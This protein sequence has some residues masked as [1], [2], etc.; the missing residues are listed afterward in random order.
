MERKR[1]RLRRISSEGEEDED[2]RISSRSRKRV[3][4]MEDEE[5]DESNE[6]DDEEEDD[7]QPGLSMQTGH[8]QRT[9]GN[10]LLPV[11]CGSKTG[12]LDVEKL[13]RGEECIMCEDH[14]FTP[15]TFED[16]G[17]KGC[18]KKWKTSIFYENKPLQ[19]WFEQGSLTTTGY[20]RRGNEST[21]KKKVPSS[22]CTSEESD[23]QLAEETEEDDVKDEDWLPGSEKLVL[24]KE[25]GEEERAGAGSR[26]EVVDSG[27]KEEEDE[28]EK[29][30]TEDE[31]IPAVADND[32]DRGVFEEREPKLT[33]SALK[34]RVLQ[35]EVKVLIKRLP[36]AKTDCQSNCTD[37]PE[38]D[39]W[40]NPLDSITAATHFEPSQTSLSPVG[41]GVEEENGGEFAQSNESK[42]HGR[43]KIK[44]ETGNSPTLASAPVTSS[45]NI[46]PEILNETA[47]IESSSPPPAVT[48]VFFGGNRIDGL[49]ATNEET[50]HC[51]EEEE[52]R[53]RAE[54]V[55][56]MQRRWLNRFECSENA[57]NEH[58]DMSR[59]EAGGQ[60]FAAGNAQ[61]SSANASPVLRDVKKEFVEAMSGGPP[62]EQVE[63]KD[64]NTDGSTSG[65][66]AAQLHV[67]SLHKSRPQTVQTSGGPQ[68]PDMEEGLPSGPCDLDAMDL[69]QLRREKLKM[70]LK[71]LKLQEEY[72]TQKMKGRKK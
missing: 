45:P 49:E 23:I 2:R 8:D 65:H 68:S 55:P 51:G 44:T 50:G 24:G 18:S 53:N 19:F 25:E 12:I 9:Q 39:S 13:D 7:D 30:E 36:Q 41:G 5:E 57:T 70:Q 40:C 47:L 64:E 58:F 27:S 20:K 56:G 71:V 63:G 33:V 29:W 21:K 54:I 72:Y 16:L 60:A 15:P 3:R 59:S 67:A 66:D 17:G 46:K 10:R 43:R 52:A 26:G 38:Q 61:D 35:N 32:K 11:T 22:N 42:E 48:L 69:D 31:D 37:H 14:W 34:K 62:T 6:E 1:I 4:Y 28:I